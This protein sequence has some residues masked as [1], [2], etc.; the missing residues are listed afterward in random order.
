MNEID[1]VKHKDM[2]E[3]PMSLMCKNMIDTSLGCYLMD[4]S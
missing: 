3:I 2:V 4:V 1:C